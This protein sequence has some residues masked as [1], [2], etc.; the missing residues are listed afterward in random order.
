MDDLSLA[1]ELARRV[2]DAGGRAYF[3]GGLVRD[4]LLGLSTEDIDVEVHGLSPAALEEILDALGE[5][6]LMGASFGIYGLRH[7]HLDI[8]MPRTE[9]ATGGGHRDFTVLVDPWLGTEKAARRRDFTVNAMLQDVLTGEILD[10]FG[11]REDLKNG[12]LRHV[13]AET[14]VEDPLRVLRGAQFAARF[15]LLL[16]PETRELCRGIDLR[17]LARERVYAELCKALLQADTP[18]VFFTELRRMGQLSVWF[19]EIEALIGVPQN[20][21]YHPEG[22]VWNHTMLVLDAAAALR[23][24]ASNPEGFM[25]SALSHDLGKPATT[26]LE[27]GRY[28]SIGHEQAGLR[29]AERLLSRL[30]SDA[31]L[32]R[33]VRN[34]T[35][36]H[37]RPNL[38]FAQNARQKAFFQMFDRACCPDD[39]LLLSKADYLG[40]QR[41]AEDYAPTGQGLCAQLAA[42]RERMAQPQ[43]TGGDLIA[44]GFSPCPAFSE[45]LRFSRQLHLAGVPKKD[46]LAQTVSYLQTLLQKKEQAEP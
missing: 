27:N 43:V 12:I 32:H 33:Y 44:A 34:M 26:R 24:Q 28:R 31:A 15:H 36:L 37:M 38:L 8:A 46:A 4:R 30:T 2:A 16:A 29:P 42:F 9:R 21:V 23:S 10:P 39:L 17:P 11:G 3:V 20:P 14:F 19:S 18:S 7:H 25:L 22:D 41:T 1:F 35:E 13:C 40:K 6:T 45:A 5:K